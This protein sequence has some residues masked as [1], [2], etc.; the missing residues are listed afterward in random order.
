MKQLS[1]STTMDKAKQA[2]ALYLTLFDP[3]KFCVS[4][5]IYQPNS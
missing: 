3:N 1:P 2:F 4:H 5:A